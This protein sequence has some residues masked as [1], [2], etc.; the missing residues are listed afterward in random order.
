MP[1]T[2]AVPLDKRFRML[3]ITMKRHQY[4][5]DILIE[6]LHTAQEMFGYLEDDVL[7]YI[8]Q[9]LKLPRSRVYGVATFYHL[10]FSQARREASL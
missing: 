2:H 3:E 1:K 4:R 7:T 6:V 10:F 5:Q 9:R 8:A